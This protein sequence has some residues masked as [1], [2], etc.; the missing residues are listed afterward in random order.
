[1]SNDF[2][3][4]FFAQSLINSSPSDEYLINLL[5]ERIK[6][7][8]GIEASYNFRRIDQLKKINKKLLKVCLSLIE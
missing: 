1:M 4:E 3:I 5:E 2:K 8:D 6:E 7:L